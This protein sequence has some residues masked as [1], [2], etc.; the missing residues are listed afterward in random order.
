MIATR[1]PPPKPLLIAHRGAMAEAP[2]NTQAA[3]DLAA[4]YPIHGFEFDVQ[5]SRD[6]IPFIFHDATLQR[7]NEAD[8]PVS[9]LTFDE[10]S[11]L[12]VGAWHSARYR[13]EKILSLDKM[14]GRFATKKTLLIEIKSYPRAGEADRLEKLT[15]LVVRAVRRFIPSPIGKQVMILSFSAEVLEMVHAIAPEIPC[16]QNLESDQLEGESHT[17]LKVEGRK[18]FCAEIGAMPRS[19]AEKCRENSFLSLTY[20]CNT[21]GQLDKALAFGVDVIMTDNPHW[22]SEQFTDAHNCG[23]GSDS[24]RIRTGDVMT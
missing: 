8:T 2:E 4:A 17:W 15:D 18:G 21:Q 5:L 16:V 10:L 12:D 11:L 3:F 24:S 19:F 9:D 20:S 7:I 13:G 14:L 6:G 23:K 22:L 1:N